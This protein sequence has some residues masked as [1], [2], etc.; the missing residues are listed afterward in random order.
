MKVVQVIAAAA[1]QLVA[2]ALCWDFSWYNAVRQFRY[3]SMRCIYCNYCLYTFPTVILVSSAMYSNVGI[4]IIY[5]LLERQAWDSLRIAWLTKNW[6]ELVITL[7]NLL[8]NL[9]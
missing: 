3:K 6:S 9:I 4:Y 7:C 2:Y 1:I 8:A 5:N